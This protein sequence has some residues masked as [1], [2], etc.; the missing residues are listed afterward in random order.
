MK[1][2]DS[3]IDG[4]TTTL[5]TTPL[6]CG[7]SS[8]ISFHLDIDDNASSLVIAVTLWVSNKDN[9]DLSSDADWVQLTA[10]HGFGG[11]PN[12]N[13][14]GGD[15][16]DF[17]DLQGANGGVYRLKFVRSAGAGT[18]EVYGSLKEYK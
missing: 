13:P 3:T 9:P 18:V 12:G 1:L 14:A 5:Y 4:T 8:N 17:L 7:E 11:L 10:A 15:F 16:K 2:L 6:F